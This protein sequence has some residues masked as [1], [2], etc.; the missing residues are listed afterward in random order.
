MSGPPRAVRWIVRKGDGGT[1]G[2]IAARAA[3]KDP[4]ALPDGRVFIGRIRAKDGK[5]TVREGDVIDVFRPRPASAEALRVL[6]HADDIVVVSKPAALA[7][8]PDHHGSAGTLVDEIARV[9][10]LPVARIRVVSRLDVGVSGVVAFALT[11]A[12]ERRLAEAR[13]R[14]EYRRAYVAIA[15]GNLPAPRGIIDAP[16][17]RHADPKKRAIPGLDPRPARTAYEVRGVAKA[18]TLV[19]L[20]PETG[21]THQLRLHLAHAGAPLLGDRLYGGVTRVTDE[22]AVHP[23]VRIALH[24][25]LI[26]VKGV[27]P[28]IEEAAP[29][30]FHTLWKA[31]GGDAS[32]WGKQG[33]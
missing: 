25:R 23:L 6:H 16:I 1:V 8:V 14:G 31:L 18:S 20:F 32:V 5:E 33:P 3:P 24:A 21:R 30:L 4:L 2:E 27:V 11:E 10:S 29:P 7:T 19:D 12:A 28:A 17:G 13:T 9:L 26:E 22:G 15:G